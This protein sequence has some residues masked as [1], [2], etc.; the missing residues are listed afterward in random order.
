MFIYII[1]FIPTFLVIIICLYNIIIR[2]KL[3]AHTT[4]LNIYAS[5]IITDGHTIN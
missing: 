5:I 1:L 4:A 2:P 3:H